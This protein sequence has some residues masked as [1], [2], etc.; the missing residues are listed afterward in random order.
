MCAVTWK[1]VRRAIGKESKL[2]GGVP[3]G[4]LKAPPNNCMPNSAKIKM[5]RKSKKRS[6]I[7]LLIELSSEITRFLSEDQYL[8]TLNILSSRSALSTDRPK[9]LSGLNSDQITS[10]MDPE[11][12]TL[13]KRLNE[14]SKYIR[15]PSAYTLI[16][17]SNMNRP[18]KPYS[19]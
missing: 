2:V 4:R 18:K 5:N 14:D 9:E 12:T 13:S 8:V 15:G 6:E 7:M 10:K 11:M 19:A 17:I 16:N 1:T 3:S